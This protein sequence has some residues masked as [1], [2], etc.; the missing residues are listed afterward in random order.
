MDLRHVAAAP[1][2]AALGI[3][4]S[5]R[6]KRVPPKCGEP[7]FS[8]YGLALSADG[9]RQRTGLPPPHRV[10]RLQAVSN[11]LYFSPGAALRA[12]LLQ[13]QDDSSL[14]R[15]CRNTGRR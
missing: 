12:H 10:S 8:E 6:P 11:L 5:A 7:R 14:L 9:L 13:R 1:E 2:R 4:Y 3:A 15:S